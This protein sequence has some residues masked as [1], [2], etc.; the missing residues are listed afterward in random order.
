MGTPACCMILSGVRVMGSNVLKYTRDT[1]LWEA[2]YPGSLA[3][4]GYK[5]Q[6]KKS[7]WRAYH[8]RPSPF[9]LKSV[10]MLKDST[11]TGRLNSKLSY[12]IT[13]MIFYDIHNCLISYM[14][15][16]MISF[17]ILYHDCE[18][19]YVVVLAP[20]PNNPNPMESFN[21][22]TDFDLQ[23]GVLVWYARRTFWCGML[24][25]L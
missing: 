15:S 10:L 21:V 25:Q 4:V 14:I 1:S 5:V 12:M 22:K 3:P 2:L 18:Q 9:M 16:S 11:R 20:Y 24:L 17:M 6:L 13:Y 8:T 7:C 23:G 19:D